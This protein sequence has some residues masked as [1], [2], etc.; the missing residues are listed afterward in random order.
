M[1]PCGSAQTKPGK[2]TQRVIVSDRDVGDRSCAVAP[3]WLPP[4]A[5][6]KVAVF[7]IKVPMMY[8]ASVVEALSV[9]PTILVSLV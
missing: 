9:M 3:N 1:V 8:P 4:W 7:P 2:G 5:C 6:V